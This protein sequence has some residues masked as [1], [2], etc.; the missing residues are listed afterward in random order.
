MVPPE[1]AH[2]KVAAGTQRVFA[3]QFTVHVEARLAGQQAMVEKADQ[4][5]NLFAPSDVRPTTGVAP[6]VQD[7]ALSTPA[8]SARVGEPPN[9]GCWMRSSQR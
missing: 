7:L 2:R 9:D 5:V 4:L 1:A 6:D 8:H 3:A